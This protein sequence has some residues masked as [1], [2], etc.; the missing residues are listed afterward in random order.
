MTAL[1]NGFVS[2]SGGLSAIQ[3]PRSET[4]SLCLLWAVSAGVGGSCI[5]SLSLNR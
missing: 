3:T 2:V 4:W 5:F 1:L